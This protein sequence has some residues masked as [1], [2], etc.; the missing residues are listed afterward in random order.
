MHKEITTLAPDGT[1]IHIIAPPE[2]K[3]SVWIGGSILASLSTFKPLWIS[4]E[5]YNE[6]G[7]AIS[8]HKLDMG[9]QQGKAD[10]SSSDSTTDTTGSTTSGELKQTNKS[11]PS[12]E[13]VRRVAKK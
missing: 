13:P 6:S 11:Q 3:Y 5:E 9:A 12:E 4:K 7:P 1:K 2:R 8:H 10:T